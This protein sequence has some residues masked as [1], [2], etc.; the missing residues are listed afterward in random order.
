MQEETVIYVPHS[1]KVVCYGKW[2][3]DSNAACVFEDEWLDGVYTDGG[4]NWTEVARVLDGYA[5][6]RNTKL[7][8]MSAV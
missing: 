3:E 7:I 1:G 5:K 8:E 6:R 4:A 2:Q